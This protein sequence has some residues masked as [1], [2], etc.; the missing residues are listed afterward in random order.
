[1]GNKDKNYLIFVIFLTFIVTKFHETF[2]CFNLVSFHYKWNWGRSVLLET[3]CTSCFMSCQTTLD[4]RK[5]DILGVSK[6][7]AGI[8]LCPFLLPKLKVQEGAIK[9]NLISFYPNLLGVL[10]GTFWGEGG[11][12][13]PPPIPNPL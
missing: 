7:I 9:L 6:L 5:E 2:Q 11:K 12:I 8:T 10:K 4:L 3:E 1:M 13:T